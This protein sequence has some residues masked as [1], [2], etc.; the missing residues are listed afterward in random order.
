[1]NKDIQAILDKY[2][3]D[4]SFL[5]SILQDIQGLYNYLPK[6]VL[7]EIAKELDIPLSTIFSV[8]TFYKAFSLTPRGKHLIQIC[9]GTAC[10]VRGATNILE[11]VK[12]KLD[13][14]PGETTDDGM[15]TLQTVNCLGACALGPIMVVDDEY[16]G[17]MT[18]SK[19]DTIIDNIVKEDRS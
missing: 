9:L 19:V 1:M 14:Q 18:Q 4:S 8:A 17:Q 11:K 15:F 16:H 10:H 7:K 12:R 6:D 5:V 2:Q 3:R 13:I